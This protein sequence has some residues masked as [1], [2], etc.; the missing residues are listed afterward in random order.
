VAATVERAR[1]RRRAEALT[2]GIVRIFVS[3]RS[4]T[5]IL[6]VFPHGLEARATEFL[7][8]SHPLPLSQ[9]ERGEVVGKKNAATDWPRRF[10]IGELWS[11][12]LKLA[13]VDLQLVEAIR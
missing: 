1:R 2:P 12:L 9:R 3:W 6:A 7:T 5:A 13:C 11:L 4:G 10:G 8:V